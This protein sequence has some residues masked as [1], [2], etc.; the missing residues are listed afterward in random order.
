M[1]MTGFFYN[2]KVF[3]SGICVKLPFG[4]EDT[5]LTRNEKMRIYK[6]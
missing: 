1:N 5:K 6:L 3:E 2:L 4:K